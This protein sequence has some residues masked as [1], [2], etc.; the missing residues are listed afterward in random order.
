MSRGFAI[1]GSLGVV[2]WLATGGVAYAQEG[3]V[4]PSAISLTGSPP[5]AAAAPAPAA[6]PAVVA[7]PGVVV[8]P[9]VVKEAPPEYAG[10][11]HDLF[12]HHVAF[13]YFGVSQLPVGLPVGG[14]GGTTGIVNAPVIGVRYWA[15]RTVGVDLGVGFGYVSSSVAGAA[16]SSDTWGFALHGGLPLSLAAS[17]HFSFE[18]VPIEVTFG[19]TGGSAPAGAGVAGTLSGLRVDVGARVGA[20]LQFGFIGIPQLALEA[21][22]GLYLEH[23]AYGQGTQTD[24]TT[25]FS[26]SVGS[27]P[28]A[29]FTDTVSALY[30]F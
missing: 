8:A 30:Y 19:F 27:D 15:T 14:V 25:T 24:Q 7:A 13:G 11:D 20:E 23:E 29:I 6:P 16:A 12:V 5:G 2:A 28:W 26:T 17:K 10:N 1:S 18:V 4:A 9:A 21:S 3:P 22:L